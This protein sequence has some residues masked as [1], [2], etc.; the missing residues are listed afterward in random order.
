MKKEPISF[1]TQ[2]ECGCYRYCDACLDE[3]PLSSADLE[4][5]RRLF[6]CFGEGW[7]DV[8][9]WSAAEFSAIA[10]GGGSVEP[11]NR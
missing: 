5:S 1:P 11:L 4:F 7:F 9:C 10:T 2:L 8:R 3:K 6:D